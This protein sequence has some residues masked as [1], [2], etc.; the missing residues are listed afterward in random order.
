M[1]GPPGDDGGADFDFAKLDVLAR[2]KLLLP[3]S[4]NRGRLAPPLR[5]PPQHCGRRER[6][7]TALDTTATRA[8]TAVVGGGY[9]ATKNL[10]SSRMVCP[11]TLTPALTATA[12]CRSTCM[13]NDT[14]GGA[15]V[16]GRPSGYW[17]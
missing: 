13:G 16:P 8:T 7:R 17:W 1:R 4:G 15:A 12:L 6:R 5:D 9:A 14:G 11:L 10:S 2:K 3:R